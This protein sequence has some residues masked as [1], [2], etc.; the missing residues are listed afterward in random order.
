MIPNEKELVSFIKRREFVNLSM[1]ASYFNIKNMTASDLVNDL[2]KKKLVE[3][4]K[5]GGSKLIR[6]KK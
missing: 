1:I 4:K 2:V 6:V 5:F 3:V